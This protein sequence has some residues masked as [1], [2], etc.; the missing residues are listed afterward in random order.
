MLSALALS[1]ASQLPLDPTTFRVV[2]TPVGAGLPAIGPV[3][4]TSGLAEYQ[5]LQPASR[6]HIRK[7]RRILQPLDKR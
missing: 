3:L 4:A 7:L 2:L 1:P 6:V 5:G